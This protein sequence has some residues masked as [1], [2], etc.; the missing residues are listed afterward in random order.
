MCSLIIE[1]YLTNTSAWNFFGYFSKGKGSFT[2]PKSSR[3]INSP[4]LRILYSTDW[5]S[6]LVWFLSQTLVDH[7][8]EYFGVALVLFFILGIGVQIWWFVLQCQHQDFHW[9]IFMIRGGTGRQLN[10]RNSE[11]PDVC[12]KVIAC[13]LMWKAKNKLKTVLI[14]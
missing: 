4:V 11:T 8:T 2:G 5:Y 6:P 12:L 10:C 7:F 9:W 3:L 1:I 13:H 14:L